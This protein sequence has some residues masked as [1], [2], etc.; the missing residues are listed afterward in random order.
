MN[1]RAVAEPSSAQQPST[2]GLFSTDDE[3]ASLYSND[4]SAI[5]FTAAAAPWLG[6]NGDVSGSRSS[7][8]SGDSAYATFPGYVSTPELVAYGTVSYVIPSE[9]YSPSTDPYFY[10]SRIFTTSAYPT[11]ACPTAALV[12][13]GKS[14]NDNNY[15]SSSS[16]PSGYPR[17]TAA[18]SCRAACPSPDAPAAATTPAAYTLCDPYPDSVYSFIV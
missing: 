1:M 9:A 3:S 14:C 10:P 11:A 17:A 6:Q 2:A 5:T 4:T 18:G 8:S 7:S 15:A 13:S 16:I 12:A